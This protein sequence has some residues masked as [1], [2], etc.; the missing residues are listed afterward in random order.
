MVAVDGAERSQR[1]VVF[2][3][4]LSEQESE[5]IEEA[6]RHWRDAVEVRRVR[7]VRLSSKC[8]PV[9]RIAEALDVTRT[10]VRRWIRLY[11]GEG[12][13]GLKTKPR[14]GRPAKVDDEYRRLLVQVVQTPPRELGYSFNRW[15]LAHLGLYMDRETGVTVCPSRLRRIL[16][17]LG[18][19]YKRPRHDLSHRR[20]PQ[21]Y[22]LKK[23][24]LDDLKKGLSSPTPATTCSLWTSRKC[25]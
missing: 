25:I 20:D 12:L 13:E 1:A 3:R 21:L 14:P 6:L 22:R 5:Q 4:E 15:T 11:E 17:E 18:Y 7:A 24:E 2:V 9:P 16:K 8:W 19:V 10:S 23:A